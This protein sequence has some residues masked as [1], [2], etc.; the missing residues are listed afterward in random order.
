ML[1]SRLLV[2]WVGGMLDALLHS[3]VFRF[4]VFN[5][6]VFFVR[7]MRH[8][9]I[10]RSRCPRSRVFSSLGM[11]TSCLL[12][13]ASHP[14]SHS[15]PIDSSELCAIPGRIWASLV[16]IGSCGR[17]SWHASVVDCSMS[18]FGNSGNH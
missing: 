15:L 8:S 11:T 5:N 17:L 4:D 6:S 3:I 13:F 7:G 12:K 2:I 9:H 14:A 18:P 1:E 10:G 16:V